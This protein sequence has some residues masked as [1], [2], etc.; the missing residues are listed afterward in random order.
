MNWYT[1]WE[2]KCEY[3]EWLGWHVVGKAWPMLLDQSL[4]L[5]PTCVIKVKHKGFVVDQI[6]VDF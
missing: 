2:T 4:L 3:M 5:G 6:L 1:F